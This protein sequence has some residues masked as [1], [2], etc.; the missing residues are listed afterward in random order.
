MDCIID[1]LRNLHSCHCV[2]LFTVSGRPRLLPQHLQNV[3]VLSK[4][5][6]SIPSYRIRSARR[7]IRDDTGG[8]KWV[9]HNRWK[10]DS[11]EWFD[12]FSGFI[13]QLLSSLTTLFLFDYL[14]FSTI[15]SLSLFT[16][17]CIVSVFFYRLILIAR[18]IRHPSAKKRVIGSDG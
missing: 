12:F 6:L 1:N 18:K 17:F 3:T 15:V 8:S 2:R 4:I 16:A 11:V 5:P 9:F 13:L 10:R 7:D 14:P